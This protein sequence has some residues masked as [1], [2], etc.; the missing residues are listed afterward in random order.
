M[1]SLVRQFLMG[2][3][4]RRT[5]PFFEYTTLLLP[6]N[7]TDSAQNNW[8]LD[9]STN[10]FPI[11]RNG[12]A[13]QGTF[14]PFSQT[15]WGNYLGTT[16][17]RLTTATSNSAFSFGTGG[18]SNVG[19][20]TIEGF[21]NLNGVNSSMIFQ[22]STA[23]TGYN[24]STSNT[25]ALYVGDA[26][27]AGKIEIYAANSGLVSTNVVVT[28]AD[29]GQWRHFAI[30]RT[31]GVTSVYWNGSI[32]AGLSAITDT[33]NYT[34]TY[35][36]IGTV[37]NNTYGL[38][39]YLSNFRVVKG[40]S[41]YSGSTI[42]I[43]TSTL[44]AVTNTSFLIANSNRFRDISSNAIGLNT[45]GSP[46]VQAFSPFNPTSSWSAATNGGSGY[47]DGS[48]DSVN[49]SYN[50]ALQLTSTTAFTIEGFVYFNSVS[51][52]QYLLSNWTTG[53]NGYA[54]A[55]GVAAFADTELCF[56]DGGGWR[57]IGNVTIGQWFHF[58]CVSSGTSSSAYIYLNGVQTS[59]A[60]TVSAN[61]SNGSSGL[62]LMSQNNSSA[63]ANG[64]LS[65]FR[66]IKGSNIYP[67][68]TSFTPP[69]A[70]LTNITNTSLLLNFTNAGIY[71]ATGRNVIETVSD[72]RTTSAVA[73]WAGQTSIS[74]DG[75][76]DYLAITPNIGA[77]FGSGNWT[78][79][80][81]IKFNN[82]SGGVLLNYGYESVSTRGFVIYLSSGIRMAQSPDGSTNYDL[83][84][85][86]PTLNTTDWF[87]LAFVRN[88]STITCYVNGTST[89]TTITA[90]T[91]STA[92]G[93]LRVGAD[94]TPSLNGYIQDLRIT[95]GYARYTAN[96][97][98]PTAAFPTL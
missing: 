3:S 54:I 6:G 52:Q 45:S 22:M 7:G 73:K 16:S 9:S 72:A 63:Y 11:T 66:L 17:D 41:L 61:I 35:C 20:F 70:P 38:K 8:F 40:T 65:N 89:G 98:P 60:F 90:Y 74:F 83:S 49:L 26:G 19:D 56:Y 44:T 80:F 53:S 42:T 78:I 57:K 46:S 68:G 4:S 48:G 84:L 82:V 37:Y 29:I 97:T 69:T 36:V 27:S 62:F 86:S 15:G 12:N 92:N 31:S 28:S 18:A 85:G 47:F 10:N 13:T 1:D 50:A 71:D 21:L 24:P 34:M 39:G 32:V 14:S 79:D 5:D 55:T 87:H 30:V 94:A 43:P 59:G 64:Y 95:R 67:N 25:I 33:T 75:T 91:I 81:W 93:F 77:Q 88:G 58:A 76:G 2:S 23:S 51:A 96:F